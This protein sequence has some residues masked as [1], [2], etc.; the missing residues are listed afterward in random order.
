MEFTCNVASLLT[1]A[2]AAARIIHKHSVRPIRTMMLISA[3]T[4]IVTIRAINDDFMI[5][6]EIEAFSVEPG[7][8]TVPVLQLRDYLR[9]LPNSIVKITQTDAGVLVVSGG[10]TATRARSVPG[11]RAQDGSC[12]LRGSRRGRPPPRAANSIRQR[13]PAVRGGRLRR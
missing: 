7:D 9:T 10:S 5:I 2:E 12:A 6:Q 4:D 13:P 1:T 3:K 8:I 11:A